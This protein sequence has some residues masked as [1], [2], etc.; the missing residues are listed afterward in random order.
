MMHLFAC[1]QRSSVGLP[2]MVAQAEGRLH[3]QSEGG[4]NMMAS[5]SRASTINSNIRASI[6]VS[7]VSSR[8]QSVNP[9]LGVGELR[10]QVLSAM[11]HQSRGMIGM[12]SQPMRTMR[13]EVGS[14]TANPAGAGVRTFAQLAGGIPDLNL[15]PDLVVSGGMTRVV[16]PQEVVDRQLAKYQLAL[17][18]GVY[19]KGL[20]LNDM[21]RIIAE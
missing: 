1:Q 3:N 11:P 14:Q 8:V 20:L 9:F 4:G 12:S 19:T 7:A 16:L 13:Q 21:Y 2:F 15:L 6:A 10:N 17:I 18:G 5:G